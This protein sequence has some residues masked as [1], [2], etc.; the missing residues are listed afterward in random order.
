VKLLLR[1]ADK[2]CLTRSYTS[3]RDE[4]GWTTMGANRSPVPMKPPSKETLDAFLAAPTL[5]AAAS[6]PK[7]TGAMLVNPGWRKPSSHGFR[8]N[9]QGLYP[10]THLS[11]TLPVLDASRTEGIA[12]LDSRSGGLAGSSSLVLLR[13]RSDGQ[14]AISAIYPVAVS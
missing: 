11:I 13:Q 10:Y 5:D 2:G 4:C 3:P 7:L 14:W 9:R 6:C 1:D 8:P 12:W